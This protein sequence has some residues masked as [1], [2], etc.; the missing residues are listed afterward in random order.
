MERPNTNSPE[1]G[2]LI[3][4][5]DSFHT[6]L[7]MFLVY[8]TCTCQVA[9]A[10]TVILANVNR[11]V[12]HYFPCDTRPFSSSRCHFSLS[13][14]E[15]IVSKP[16]ACR[17]IQ[18]AGPRGSRPRSIFFKRA[19]WHFIGLDCC[20]HISMARINCVLRWHTLNDGLVVAREPEKQ[21]DC[22]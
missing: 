4:D 16:R 9:C 13:V 12:S 3:E 10:V 21:T 5:R 15:F 22:L 18:Y 14:L 2:E 1:V 8:G 19:S 6:K 17:G 20:V 11:T 7:E